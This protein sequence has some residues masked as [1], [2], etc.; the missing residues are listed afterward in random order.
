LPVTI[1]E[2]AEAAGVSIA[3]V[4][5]ALNNSDHPVNEETRA[6]ILQI[7]EM[8]EYSPNRA[9]RSLRTDRSSVIGVILDNF[10]SHWAPVI[11]RGLQDVLH[12]ANYFCLVV[13]IPWEIHSQTKVVQ[14]LLA[15]SVDGFV[16]VETWHRVSESEA[17][18][19]GKP[20]V[21]VHRLFHESSPYSV[22]PDE[23]F[24]ET[25]AVNH[26][27]N[28]GYQKI[29]YIMGPDSYFSS[30]ERLTAYR[31]ALRTAG[32]PIRDELIESGDW[33]IPAGYQAGQR[34]LAR[35]H[36]PT[37][38]VAANDLL[39]YGAIRAIQD[40]GLHVPD[41]VAVVGYDNDEI[42]GIA[43]PTITTVTLP[44]FE[45]GQ[46]AARTLLKQLHQQITR[47]EEKLVRGQLIIRQSC[48]APEGEAVS[49]VTYRRNRSTADQPNY[50]K[51]FAVDEPTNGL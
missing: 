13:N 18:L 28:L 37:A 5:R 9:A 6:R 44:L 3:T 31:Q 26:L 11:I 27:I 39:A 22:I 29:G 47:P 12:Q 21:I 43:N 8:L 49:A 25:L 38:I 42:A 50:L 20:Y 40:V 15:H 48:G 36:P 30:H 19:N 51:A 46:I 34:L 7:A 41:D 32:I 1:H 2:I 14:D 4:S 10:N 16:F 23:R 33:D 35:P 45:M 24:N 17:M